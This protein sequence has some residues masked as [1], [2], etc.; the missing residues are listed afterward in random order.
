MDTLRLVRA[1]LHMRALAAFVVDGRDRTILGLGHIEL[2]DNTERARRQRQ[3][4]ADDL[5]RRGGI[6]GFEHFRRRQRRVGLVDARMDAP[7]LDRVAGLRPFGLGPHKVGEAGAI[8]EFVH[9]PR[10]NKRRLA[11]HWRSRE[12]EFDLFIGRH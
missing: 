8:D 4:P 2:S 9:H 6:I 12:M 1:L 7:A 10:G 5:V 11:G 3:R